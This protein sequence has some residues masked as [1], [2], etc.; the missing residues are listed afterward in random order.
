MLSGNKLLFLLG[1]FVFASCKPA[2][3]DSTAAAARNTPQAQQTQN[4]DLVTKM[5]PADVQEFYGIVKQY[6]LNRI[7]SEKFETS[8][9]YEATFLK[10]FSVPLGDKE[11]IRAFAEDMFSHLESGQLS[12][13]LHGIPK[14]PASSAPL[15][16]GMTSRDLDD[17]L[18]IVKTEYY[19]YAA[20]IQLQN[21]G[22]Q[23]LRFY[24]RLQGLAAGSMP[25]QGDILIIAGDLFNFIET[26]R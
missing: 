25:R 20:V 12:V 10:K 14:K 6:Y 7:K 22:A 11:K 5:T 16:K 15:P 19:K 13:V 17:F 2:D 8:D 24:A 4:G 1:V 9:R 21:T 3:S 23:E 18:Q 26:G